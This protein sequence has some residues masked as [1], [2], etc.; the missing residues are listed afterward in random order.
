MQEH[1]GWR[2]TWPI[3]LRYTA[4]SVAI[5]AVLAAIQVRFVYGVEGFPPQ[6]F[7]IPALVGLL[8]GFLL[9]RIRM[10]ASH[11]HVLRTFAAITAGAEAPGERAGD[12][13]GD[14]GD[15]RADRRLLEAAAREL[16]SDEIA[17]FRQRSDGIERIAHWASDPARPAC[18][19][20]ERADALCTRLAAD[21]LPRTLSGD[22]VGLAAAGR[23]DAVRVPADIPESVILVSCRRGRALFRTPDAVARSFLGLCAE[24]LGMRLT[25]SHQQAVIDEQRARHAREQRRAQIT[26]ASIGDGVLTVAP[27]GRID[28]ANPVAAQLLDRPYDA[29][30]DRPVGEV[31][32]LEDETDGRPVDPLAGDSRDPGHGDLVLRQPDDT[33]QP[34]QLTVTPVQDI[35]GTPRGHVLVLRD[36]TEVREALQH[37]AYRSSHDDLTGLCNRRRFEQLLEQALHQAR[38]G[39]CEHV[40]CYLDLDQ[41]KLINDTRGHWAG[42]EMLRQVAGMLRS[43]MRP[44]DHLAR[45]GGDEFGILMQDCDIEQGSRMAVDIASEI[46]GMRFFWEDNVFA[47]SASLGVVAVDAT[48]EST[49][50]LL[51]HADTACYAAKDSGRNQVRVYTPQ[52]SDLAD[53]TGEMHWVSR[54]PQAIERGE[55]ELWSQPVLALQ[56]GPA[57]YHELL[58]RL[59]DAQG[60]PV[61]PGIFIPAAERFDLMGQLDRW[62]AETAL[63]WLQQC[64]TRGQELPVIGINISGTAMSSEAFPEFLLEAVRNAGVPGDRLCFEITETAAVSNLTRTARFMQELRALGCR[65][66]LDD[67][68]SGLSSFTYLKSLPVDYLKID[69]S[70]VKDIEH[71]PIDL[72]M[73]R[74]IHELSGIVGLTTIAEHVENDRIGARLRDLGIPFGQGYGLAMPRPLSDCLPATT[75]QTDRTVSDARP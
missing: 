64:Q 71:D 2:E 60:N 50:Q 36:V 55:F 69:G 10:L 41:F 19:I 21:H 37:M 45:L 8:F 13:S 73:V 32:R 26:L 30:R 52:D 16:D 17:L 49:E 18:L 31:L 74:A 28:Y 66:A 20:E 72:A 62:V 29:L 56:D 48:A 15:D 46:A 11:T 39:G 6:L 42:D 22:E 43:I 61:S 1:A 38:G 24:W 14:H 68:G 63:Q 5:V 67:F 70:F 7:V 57:A 35:D 9:A 54:I 59:R 40:L 53:R 65:F 51:R 33:L 4:L 47:L 23:L 12:S 58:L 44:Q 75:P 25:R 34:V 27:D 3:Y